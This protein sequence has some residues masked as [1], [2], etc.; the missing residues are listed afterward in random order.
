M[1]LLANNHS[2]DWR[3]LFLLYLVHFV[4]LL[5]IFLHVIEPLDYNVKLF[6]SLHYQVLLLPIK[7]SYYNQ[8]VTNEVDF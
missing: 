5:D 7:E 8:M 1:N 2:P 3:G 4:L 6:V